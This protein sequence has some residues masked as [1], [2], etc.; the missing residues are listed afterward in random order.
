MKYIL[1]CLFA[2]LALSGNLQAEPFGDDIDVMGVLM[3][4]VDGEDL[5]MYVPY[6]RAGNR[7]YVKVQKMANTQ[8]VNITA[9][10]PTSTGA[11][12]NPMAQLFVSLGADGIP[13]SIVVRLSD[14]QG[15]SRPLL[16]NADLGKSEISKYQLQDDGQVQIGFLA[17]LV[18]VDAAL[19][20]TDPP[21]IE[22]EPNVRVDGFIEF[23]LEPKLP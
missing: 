17:T 10:T 21:I 6:D 8:L 16:A 14:E 18:R 4:S 19:S 22:G 5:I 23:Y 15:V 9:A 1:S 12:G 2:L 20:M 3:L 7:S 11:P 13:E